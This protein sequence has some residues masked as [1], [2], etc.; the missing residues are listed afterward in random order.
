MDKSMEIQFFTDK[1][2]NKKW[3]WNNKLHRED[4]P[5]IE[6]ADGAKEWYI[7]GKLHREDGPAIITSGGKEYWLLNGIKHR[8]DGPAIFH[9]SC[10]KNF[11]YINGK[12]ITKEVHNLIE[13]KTFPKLSRWNDSD[14]VKFKLM[15]Y[16]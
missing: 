10:G 14:I 8:D 6:Y 4:G 16:D 3:T 13:N 15:F 7:D 5:A 9:R 2:G 11:W 1:H 12:D